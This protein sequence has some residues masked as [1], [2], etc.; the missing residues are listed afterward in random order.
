MEVDAVV[1]GDV[2]KDPTEGTVVTNDELDVDDAAEEEDEDEDVGDAA[3]V[4]EDTVLELE[5]DDTGGWFGLLHLGMEPTNQRSP[6]SLAYPT[7]FEYFSFG[8]KTGGVPFRCS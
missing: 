5:T 2:V 3:T 1:G 4:A 8:R 7:Q 6:Q